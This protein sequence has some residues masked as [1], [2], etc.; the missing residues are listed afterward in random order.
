M[1]IF[2][3]QKKL[4]FCP[5]LCWGDYHLGWE[6]DNSQIFNQ[7]KSNQFFKVVSIWSV[8]TGCLK[9]SFTTLSTCRFAMNIISISSQLEVGSQ[10]L[11]LVKLSFI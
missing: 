9:K 6:W 7:I 8:A 5:S 3:F 11:N 10:M 4:G 1:T 2:F